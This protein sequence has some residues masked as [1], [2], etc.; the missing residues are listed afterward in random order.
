EFRRVLFRSVLA[1]DKIGSAAYVEIIDGNQQLESTEG[2][3]LRILNGNRILML[4]NNDSVEYTFDDT[5]AFLDQNGNKVAASS[6][7]PESTIIVQR[8]TY[9]AA[10]KPVL[11]QVKSALVSKSGT[12]TIESVDVTGKKVTIR[13][14]SG[15]VE[16]YA[17]DETTILL[18]QS[19]KLN[20]LNELQA[21]SAIKYSVKNSVLD[22]LEVT[23]S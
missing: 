7:T 8:E 19:Q 22:S 3:L 18:Y 6:L 17:V 15:T 14:A 4:V 1:I 10:R 5:T 2:T 21:K 13:D 16:T 12:G 9:T 23:Q 20:S 11:V